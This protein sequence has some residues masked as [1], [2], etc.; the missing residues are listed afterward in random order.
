M[1][2]EPLKLEGAYRVKL[3]RRGDE[4]GHLE[5]LFCR[6]TFL[7][8]GLA[9]CSCQT[10]QVVTHKAGTLRGLHFQHPPFNETKLVWVYRGAL[11]DVLVDLR[12]GSPTFGQWTALELRA[13]GDELVYVP[14]GFAHAYFTLTDDVGIVYHMDAPYSREHAAGIRYDDPD[15]GVA[16]PSEP[17]VLS[18]AD[19]AWPTLA[20]LGDLP[21]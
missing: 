3:D 14:K 12:R 4:R 16:W 20:E 19:R 6:E 2:L 13:G 8:A 21:F 11:Y 5:R 17:A 7:A 9:D 10:S 1:R 18:D 15:I